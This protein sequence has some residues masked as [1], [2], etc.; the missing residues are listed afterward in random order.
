[1][2]Q[3]VEQQDS[4]QQSVKKT[5]GIPDILR[6]VVKMAP[7]ATGMIKHAP[8][9]IRRPPE[10]KRTIGSVFQKHAAEH[11]DRPFVRFEGRTTTY[12][13]ANRRV[14]RYA[15]ALS[16]DGVGKGDVV[17][18]LSKNCTTDLLLMLA[19][20]KLGAIA[21]MLNYNQRGEV[22]EHSVG[23]LEAKVLIHD[24]ECAEAFE[25]I[26]ESVLPEHVYDF[27]A[28]DAAAEGLSE[29]D[30]EVTEQL[31]ASTKAFYIFTSGTTGMPKAS[32][33]THYRWLRALAG[34]GGLGM[35]LNSHD[36]LYCCLPLYHNNALTVACSS[37]IDTLRKSMFT[38]ASAYSRSARRSGRRAA[39]RSSSIAAAAASGMAFPLRVSGRK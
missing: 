35:R 22:L 11:P 2:S 1:M 4:R 16:A 19:T 26:P 15:A 31:P 36:T 23:L 7:H 9:L 38:V 39:A 29:A 14:N 5:V 21:G 10:A 33:M 8:G 18:L 12:G 30:P 28:F 6:G 37:V 32:V 17:A 34:F 24:P 27:A 13:E 25:S 3:G 20:V